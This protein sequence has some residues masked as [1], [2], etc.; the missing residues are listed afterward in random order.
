MLLTERPAIGPVTPYM[1]HHLIDALIMVDERDVA[2]QVMKEYWGEMIEDGA[3]TFWESYDPKNKNFSPYG[4]SLIN[5]YCTWSCTRLTLF[6]NIR[7][8]NKKMVVHINGRP[9]PLTRISIDPP[10]ADYTL[11]SCSIQNAE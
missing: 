10:P 2:R 7:C 5:S 3:D 9:L 6:A 8:I 11:N 4:N 1:Y